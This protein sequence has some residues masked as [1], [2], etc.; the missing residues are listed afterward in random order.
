MGR[1]VF[2]LAAIFACLSLSTGAIAHAMEPIGCIDNTTAASLGH[3]SGDGDQ[4]PSDADKGYAHHHGGCHGH[5]VCDTVRE[6]PVALYDVKAAAQNPA[7]V[8]IIPADTA[9]PS[10]RPPIA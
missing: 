5:Q 1:V 10:L 3:S 2:I 6:A 9:D 7:N 4:V 8:A